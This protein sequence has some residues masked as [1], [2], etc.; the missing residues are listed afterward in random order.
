MACTASPSID[1]GAGVRPPR[2]EALALVC[3]SDAA[4]L[5]W[6]RAGLPVVASGWA[7]VERIAVATPPPA[8]RPIV[9]GTPVPPAPDSAGIHELLERW[10]SALKRGDVDAATQCYAPVV[11][12][13]FGRHDVTREVVR[14]SITAT[15][16]ATDGGRSHLGIDITPVS[17]DRAVA[18]FRKH[19]QISGRAKSA[20]EEEERMTLVRTDG[21]WQI[22]SEQRNR[23][24]QLFNRTGTCATARRSCPAGASGA[25]WCA[26]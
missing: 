2:P 15:A 22:S 20:G 17:D 3:G 6:R 13:Y 26:D 24:R 11:S 19:W 8:E 23:S 21:V 1:A 18:T 4:R 25:G 9:E 12:T 10:L 5:G 14:Q 16:R 7:G